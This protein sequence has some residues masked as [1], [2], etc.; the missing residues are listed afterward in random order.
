MS[1][2]YLVVAIHKNGSSH[3]GIF[4]EFPMTEMFDT[5][6]CGL[7]MEESGVDFNTA[8]LNL[9]NRL[10]KEKPFVYKILLDNKT[11]SSFV[12]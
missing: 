12:R 4:S 11:V 9:I 1:T 8:G 6:V 2:A 7:V 10:K 3:I 5:S